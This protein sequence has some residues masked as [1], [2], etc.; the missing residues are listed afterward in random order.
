MRRL[1]ERH[2]ESSEEP[3]RSERLESPLKNKNKVLQRSEKHERFV[4]PTLEIVDPMTPRTDV[5]KFKNR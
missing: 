4:Y 5:G 2:S 1:A 3:K